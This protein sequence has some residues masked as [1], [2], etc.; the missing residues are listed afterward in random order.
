MA[1]DYS[2][3]MLKLKKRIEA[4]TGFV[5]Y[6]VQPGDQTIFYG[7]SDKLQEFKTLVADKFDTGTIVFTM[8]DCIKQMYSKYKNLWYEIN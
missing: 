2:D 3:E 4:E 7:T 1:L 6:E 5:C 8:D